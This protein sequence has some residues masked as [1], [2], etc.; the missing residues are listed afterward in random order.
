MS[1]AILF[2]QRNLSQRYS[3]TQLRK[4]LETLCEKDVILKVRRDTYK[5]NMASMTFCAS[6]VEPFVSNSTR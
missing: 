6:V 3:H 2:G 1:S 4:A 5:P